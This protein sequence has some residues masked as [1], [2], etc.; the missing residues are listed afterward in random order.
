MTLSISKKAYLEV[1]QHEVSS[2]ASS[3][4]SNSDSSSGS[5]N[6]KVVESPKYWRSIMYGWVLGMVHRRLRVAAV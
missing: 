5:Q 1:M 4:S 2:S 3:A 6:P